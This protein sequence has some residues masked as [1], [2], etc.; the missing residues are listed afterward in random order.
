MAATLAGIPFFSRRKS[1]ARYCF[2]WPPPRCQMVI[3]L[4]SSIVRKR[5]DAVYGLKVFSAIVFLVLNCVPQVPAAGARAGKIVRR[6]PPVPRF[7]FRYRS[8]AY[9]A[10]ELSFCDPRFLQIVRVLD[11]FFA[12]RELHV[13]LLP[14]A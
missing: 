13:S 8:N 11:H 5:R 9:L 3:S 6:L 2:L 1:M 12:G 7:Y 10:S 14:V 4:L